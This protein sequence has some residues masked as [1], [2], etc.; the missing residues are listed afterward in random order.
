[1]IFFLILIHESTISFLRFS[2]VDESL[3]VGLGFHKEAQDI[4]GIRGEQ[5]WLNCT[6]YTAPE[7]RPL[8]I[9][10]RH[11]GTIINDSRRQNLRN[12]SLYFRRVL[13]RKQ[14]GK[15]DE[16]FYECLA[17]NQAGTIVSR[18]VRLQ[19]ASKLNFLSFLG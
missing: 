8:T 17:Q 9:Q 4:I 15:S 12:G 10:W 3:D 19:V 5:L 13:H 11:N 2:D 6:A 16:G 18:K 14:R 7:L 1:M